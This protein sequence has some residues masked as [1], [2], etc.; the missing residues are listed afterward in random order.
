MGT[1]G[2]RSGI[3]EMNCDMFLARCGDISKSEVFKE[4]FAPC[5]AAAN[6]KLEFEFDIVLV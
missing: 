4:L 6:E 2:I 1:L 3:G 5:P